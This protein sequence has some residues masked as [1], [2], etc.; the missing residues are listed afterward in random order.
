MLYVRRQ[1][2]RELLLIGDVV[3]QKYVLE[4]LGNRRRLLASM[5][6]DGIAGEHQIRA[7]TEVAKGN[8]SLDAVVSHD[9]AAMDARFASG[10]VGRQLR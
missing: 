5:M 9:I 6:G 7:V 4:Q 3:W 2:G 10:A 8:P 1:G